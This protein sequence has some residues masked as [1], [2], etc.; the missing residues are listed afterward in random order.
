M[1]PI[2]QQPTPP[3]QQTVWD[4]LR[5]R[6]AEIQSHDP[7]VDP[8]VLAAK[9]QKRARNL[10]TRHLSEGP[11]GP[12]LSFLAFRKGRQRFGLATDNVL[13]VLALN[14]ISPVPWTPSFVC[15]AIHWRGAILTLLDL[16]KLFGLAESGIADTHAAIVVEAA[17]RRVALLSGEIDEIHSVPVDSLHSAMELPGEMPSNWLLGIHDETRMILRLD[18]ILQD[19]KLTRWRTGHR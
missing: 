15:G 7:R 17:G 4:R 19:A 6:M 2:E 9:L 10:Q 5:E 1:K 13:E 16:V 18:E 12:Q 3:S 11:Q 8:E 14:Q